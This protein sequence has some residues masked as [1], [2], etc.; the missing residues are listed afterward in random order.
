[1][2]DARDYLDLYFQQA[3]GKPILN[4]YR[5]GADEQRALSL[6]RLG[7]P[8][9]AGH[10]A[11]L[12]VRYVLLTP[13]RIVPAVPQPGRPGPGLRRV[14]KDAYG[15]LYRVIARP[16]PFV[17]ARSGLEPPEGPAGS[18]YRWVS[19]DA[20]ELE[21][22][23][24]CERCEGVLQFAAASFGEGRV[25]AIGTEDGAPLKVVY[26]PAEG[27]DISVPLRFR[28]RTVVRLTTKPGP[29]SIQET[30][31]APDPRTVSISIRNLRFESDR[32]P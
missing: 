4:G 6:T 3:H 32:S 16:E 23:A 1:V 12:G 20:A 8:S 2:L 17:F 9:T 22:N 24:A 31:G 30:T 5:S 10:L 28:R 13:H 27:K 25:V 15:T 7:D 11:T 29:V 19:G 21:I 14:G 26:V 18:Q